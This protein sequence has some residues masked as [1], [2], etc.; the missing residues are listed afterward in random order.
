MKYLLI[1]VH[2]RGAAIVAP[3]VAI[4]V[5]DLQ[6]SAIELH[7]D[8]PL[9]DRELLVRAAQLRA[10][11]LDAATFIAVR[12]GA[13][14]HTHAEVERLVAAKAARWAELLDRYGDCVEMTMK[15]VTPPAAARP[16]RADATSGAEYLRALHAATR[17][18]QVPEAFRAAVDASLGALAVRSRWAPRDEQSVEC[19][20]LVRRA[21]V[22]EARSRA[23]ALRHSHPD[24]PFLFSGPWPL[25]TFAD[26]DDHE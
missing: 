2:R 11:L 5:G 7:D 25:E 8:T 22:E 20:L 16:R 13:A 19:A 17:S 9:A 14:P 3:A 18:A 26:D 21:D 12:Y 10:R 1:G 4:P 24:V 6:V 15:V 23:E